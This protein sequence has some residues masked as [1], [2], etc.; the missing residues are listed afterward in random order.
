LSAGYR[1]QGEVAFAIA[2][3]R[4][5]LAVHQRET[6][7]LVVLNTVGKARTLYQQLRVQVPC[8]LLH[9]RFRAID[10]ERVTAQ[11]QT[12]KGIVIATQV[13]EAGIDL[14]A[15]LLFAELAPWA[16]LVQR[17]GRCG[18]RSTYP[19]AL[20][21][22]VGVS[23]DCTDEDLLP[24]E[25]SE[26]KAA[27]QRLQGL[28]DAGIQHLLQ[29]RPP[30]QP[31]LGRRLTEAVFTELFD[32][33]PPATGRDIGIAPYVREI[34]HLDVMVGWRDWVG[35]QPPTEWVLYSNELCRVSVRS[36][37]KFS[38][39]FCWT[40]DTIVEGWQVV[41]PSDVKPG[42]TLLLPCG[43]GGYSEETGWTGN[44]SD[45]PQSVASNTIKRATNDSDRSSFTGGS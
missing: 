10:R 33:S 23:S 39:P 34:Q 2:L 14:D 22:W 11:L 26:L 1:V 18:R 17:F 45:I 9:S 16:S 13:V 35:S 40:W 28:T 4:E 19:D 24:Y 6:L 32:T 25:R 29:I 44:P 7:S 12:F 42:Q 38:T 36:L 21:C 41:K 8:L 20:I 3:A 30:Q 15:R 31:Q 5:I 27:E 37:A 43:V